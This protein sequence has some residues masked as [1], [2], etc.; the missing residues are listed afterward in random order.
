MF[1]KKCRAHLI[2]NEMTG[3]EHLKFAWKL[4][5]ICKKTAIGLVI[6]GLAPRLCQNSGTNGIKKMREMMEE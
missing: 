5:W 3:L 2:E 1:S 4:A 6:H